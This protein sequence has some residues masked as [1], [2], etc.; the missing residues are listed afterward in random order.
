M[1]STVI[2]SIAHDKRLLT[3]NSMITKGNFPRSLRH[4]EANTG[5]KPLSVFIN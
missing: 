1:K 4:I 5:F 2:K 3:R